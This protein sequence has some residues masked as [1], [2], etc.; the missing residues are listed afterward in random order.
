MYQL[1]GVTELEKAL[2]LVLEC[3]LILVEQIVPTGSKVWIE[4]VMRVDVIS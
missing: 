3:C 2:E 1:V 4:S